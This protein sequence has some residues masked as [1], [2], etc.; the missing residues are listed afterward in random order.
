MRFHTLFSMI[1]INAIYLFNQ[2]NAGAFDPHLANQIL[3]SL[4]PCSR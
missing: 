4:Q 2:R 3:V 1:N